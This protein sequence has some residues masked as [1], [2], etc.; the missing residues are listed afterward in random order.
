VGDVTPWISVARAM[1]VEERRIG[2]VRVPRTFSRRR[3]LTLWGRWRDALED[4]EEALT[5]IDPL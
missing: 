1:T 5:P 4:H 2:L 3:D